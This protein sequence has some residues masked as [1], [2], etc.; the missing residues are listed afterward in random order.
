[1]SYEFPTSLRNLYQALFNKLRYHPIE[2]PTEAEIAESFAPFIKT[3][4]DNINNGLEITVGKF[5]EDELIPGIKYNSLT[6]AVSEAEENAHITVK[7][8]EYH[9][10]GNI[11]IPRSMRI[12]LELG[13]TII[14]DSV[15][16]KGYIGYTS[17]KDLNVTIDGMGCFKKYGFI[18]KGAGLYGAGTLGTNQNPSA[19]MNI[20]C[21]DI[22]TGG[23]QLI[24]WNNLKQ[25][26]MKFRNATGVNQTNMFDSDNNSGVAVFDFQRIDC[27]GTLMD[28]N[29]AYAADITWKNGY[30][31]HTKGAEGYI[32]I[33]YLAVY[34]GK[35]KFENIRL[36]TDDIIHLGMM[37]ES[38]FETTITLKDSLFETDDDHIFEISTSDMILLNQ[39]SYVN[40]PET[41]SGVF[42]GD[43]L[44]VES[45]LEVFQFGA[46]FN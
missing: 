23:I 31:Y 19:T 45:N 18:A 5:E 7:Q 22:E 1:M 37:T 40:K 30:I 27:N 39:R 44:A 15:T 13:A 25:I 33:E 4:N 32:N 46:K 14:N 38:G 6:E 20:E 24:Y 16:G 36:K 8:G 21:L 11:E 26:N 34:N 9:E 42:T 35:L 10:P 41:G 2:E 12:T 3:V 43:S 17:N 29:S 28:L